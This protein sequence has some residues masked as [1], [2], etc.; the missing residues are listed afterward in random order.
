MEISIKNRTFNKRNEKNYG[1]YKTTPETRICLEC[2][3]PFSMCKKDNCKRYI[4]KTN[5]LKKKR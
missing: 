1:N 3:L 2:D 5:E 4:E